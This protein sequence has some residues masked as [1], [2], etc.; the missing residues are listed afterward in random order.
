MS[1]YK[2]LMFTHLFTVAPCFFIGA[3]L[4]A[5]NKGTPSHKIL[6]KIYM[7]L[8]FFTASVSL[9]IPALVGPQFLNHFGFIHLFSFLTLYS[10][11][12]ALIAVKKGNIKRHKWSMIQL[13]VGALV[14]AG[15]FTLMPGRYLHQVF[16]G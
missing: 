7:T 16:F 1:T 2:I 4:M 8:M 14:I 9:F 12:T 3:Y 5:F 11:P 15:G 13:Y 10:V 6:G